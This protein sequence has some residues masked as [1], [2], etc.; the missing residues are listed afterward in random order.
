MV[1]VCIHGVGGIR[2]ARI[3]G[4]NKEIPGSAGNDVCREIFVSDFEA[5]IDHRRDH[6][7]ARETEG[8]EYRF[9]VDVHGCDA[10]GIGKGVL[11][12]VLQVP[13]LRGERV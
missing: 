8:A 11:S 1:A 13:L 10:T 3:I 6:P 2:G 9:D 12:G 5:G 7:V 4:G